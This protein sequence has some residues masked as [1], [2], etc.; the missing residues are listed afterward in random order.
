MNKKRVIDQYAKELD[1]SKDCSPMLINELKKATKNSYIALPKYISFILES[2]ACLKMYIQEQ[3]DNNGKPINALL[4]NMQSDNAAFEG[5]AIVL[6][7]LIPEK[8][9]KI[10]LKW[11]APTVQDDH[12]N[13]FCYRVI[14][15]VEA[16]NWFSVSSTNQNDINA[17]QTR[18][19]DLQNNCG[20]KIPQ[21]KFKKEGHVGENAVEYDMVHEQNFPTFLCKHYNVP[22]I[23]HQLPVG[24][25]QNN[26][27]F[28]AGTKAAID[29]WG[30]NN[31][32]LTIIE[33]KY[34]NK[35]VGIISELFFYVSL[36]RDIVL[37]RISKPKATLRYEK[38][39]Y[40][41]IDHIRIIHARM[42]AD[43]YHPLIDNDSVFSVLN[44]NL[45]KDVKI[46]FD[47]SLYSYT[48]ATLKIL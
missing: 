35:M 19:H 16:F 6:K 21:K 2:N 17:F 15:M 20:N 36:M 3:T 43:A 11:D 14:K 41:D 38:D 25:K 10:E 13:R 24:V 18:L 1:D 33:L 39:L 45:L 37:G 42:L 31:N 22:N 26:K 28:F 5:W 23:Y 48:P 46:D 40:K 12:Y 27:S 44:D 7:A 29:L 30:I 9:N 4:T 32:E 34:Q 47:K 8:I